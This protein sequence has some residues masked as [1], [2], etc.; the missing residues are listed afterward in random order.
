MSNSIKILNLRNENNKVIV[1]KLRD[2]LGSNI[3]NTALF[4]YQN[5][6]EPI[7]YK[8]HEKQKRFMVE[9]PRFNMITSPSAIYLYLK[10]E[11][12]SFPSKCYKIK[13][14]DVINNLETFDEINNYINEKVDVTPM[15]ESTLKNETILVLDNLR[16]GVLL[17]NI[18]KE[19]AKAEEVGG[20][21]TYNDLFEII[22]S[23]FCDVIDSGYL[24]L[25]NK[26]CVMIWETYNDPSSVNFEALEINKPKKDTKK[27]KSSK[28]TNATPVNENKEAPQDFVKPESFEELENVNDPKEMNEVEID[29]TMVENVLKESV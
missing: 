9:Y 26:T 20:A 5:G 7:S 21:I 4:A 13:K 2:K 16:I 6:V 15:L 28:K 19:R 10:R 18:E 11:G 22:R 8:F 23:K 14:T 25:L 1:E 27:I 12:E 3:E 24:D 17:K 29:N